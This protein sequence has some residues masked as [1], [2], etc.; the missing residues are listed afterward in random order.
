MG[1]FPTRRPQAEPPKLSMAYDKPRTLVAAATRVNLNDRAEAENIRQRTAN[2]EW[3]R[4]A[5]V[6]YDNIGEIKFAF[7]LV[8]NILSRVRLYAAA[9][10]DPEAP[11]VSAADAAGIERPEGED[12]GDTPEGLA[13]PIHPGLAQDAIRYMGMLD[14]AQIM[15]MGGL[16]LG[17]AGECYLALVDSKWRAY[18]TQE[19]RVSPDGKVT[20]RKSASSGSGRDQILPSDT[21]I[22]RIW[23]QHPQFSDDPDSS[24]RAVRAECEELLLLGREIRGVTR[25]RMGAGILFVPDA[26]SVAARNQSEDAEV[27]SD[28]DVFEAELMAAMLEP[29]SDE[30]SGSSVVPMLIRGPAELGDKIKFL[31]LARNT[32]SGL[33]DR[34]ER[35]LERV[36][37]GLDVPKDIVT[38]LANVKYSNA[39]KISEDLYAA[40]IDPLALLIAD[41]LTE[42]YL[43]PM[44]AAAGWDQDQ[45]DRMVVWYDSSDV[46]TQPD[47]SADA[48]A[49]YDRRVISA[50][51]WRRTRGFSDTDAPSE[52]ETAARIAIEKA[53][54]DPQTSIALLQFLLPT[55]LGAAREANLEAEGFPDDLSQLLGG[56]SAAPGEAATPVAEEVPVD[57]AQAVPETA[58]APAEAVGAPV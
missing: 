15:R 57:A 22:G 25:S 52:E 7:G 50:D 4:E 8:S 6:Y 23:R 2:L 31:Q 37:Q 16:N 54:V 33:V 5:W 39:I 46:V 27:A 42:I 21:P 3:Q 10:V 32:D 47:R 29:I 19:I 30:S 43:R 48:D 35:L 40:H 53:I 51:A 45:V 41:A 28:E 9:V 34:S 14:A 38:G 44:L 17:V 26:L 58:G 18:S 24:M 12:P 55:I 13:D 56:E 49:G 20:R 11:P 1:L 36:L